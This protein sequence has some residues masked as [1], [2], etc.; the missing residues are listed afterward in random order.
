MDDI[1]NIKTEA[2]Q[3]GEDMEH[4]FNLRIDGLKLDLIERVTRSLS[5]LVF[6]FV[7]VFFVFAGLFI[8]CLAAILIIYE[9]A[10]NWVISSAG[11]ITFFIAMAW[12]VISKG[13]PRLRD[14]ITRALVKSTFDE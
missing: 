7:I 4:Y 12:F 1:N 9:F 14:A 2:G 13:R 6:L 10:N 8:V 3:I 5:D 11:A